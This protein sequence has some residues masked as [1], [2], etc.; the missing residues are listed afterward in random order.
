MHSPVD[1]KQEWAARISHTDE[2][3]DLVL[4]AQ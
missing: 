2:E 4:F 3:V 1:H